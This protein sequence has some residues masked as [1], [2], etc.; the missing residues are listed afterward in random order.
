MPPEGKYKRK[1]LFEED[2][3]AT[4]AKGLGLST[5]RNQRAETEPEEGEVCC[6]VMS[7]TRLSREPRTQSTVQSEEQRP[8]PVRRLHGCP[9]QTR[10]LVP[11]RCLPMTRWGLARTTT[12]SSCC[13]FSAPVRTYTRGLPRGNS[14]PSAPAEA[15]LQ[16]W[17]PWTCWDRQRGQG[18]AAWVQS[19]ELGHD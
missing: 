13:M 3:Q 8:Q 9:A 10:G 17:G 15:E 12:K 11:D 2:L 4:W 16:P 14:T 5:T 7:E 18:P 1:A 19:S 6:L